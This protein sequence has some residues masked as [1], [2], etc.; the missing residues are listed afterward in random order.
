MELIQ[1]CEEVLVNIDAYN[2]PAEIRLLRQL[3]RDGL[4][5][6]KA[7]TA[8]Q[9]VLYPAS[10]WFSWAGQMLLLLG[11]TLVLAGII[12]FFAYNWAEMSRLLKFALIE[13]GIVGCVLAAYQR[14]LQQLSG[15]ILLLSASVLVGVLLAVYGQV[16]QTGADAFG[17]F[18][19]WAALIFAW[20]MIGEF[21][22]LWLLWLV[23]LNTGAILYWQQ[24]GEP[25]HSIPYELLCLAIAVL[26]GI[27]LALREIGVRQDRTWLNNGWLRGLLLIAC[28]VPLSIPTIDLILAF[29]RNDGMTFVATCAW[30]AT[31]A[32]GYFCY[33]FTVPDMSALALIVMNA[34]VILL[35][36]VGNFLFDTMNFD[37]AGGFLLFALIILAVVSGAALFLRRTATAMVKV[38]EESVG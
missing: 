14:G 2:K 1:H 33:R 38:T 7:L 17:L 27:A 24:V 31:V 22:A 19:G 37:D 12:F 36:L 20:V 30:A 4:L 21:A 26:N 5:N 34:C 3:N 28:L 16:Y 10:A 6:D 25:A 8:A 11:S 18:L 29:G 35:T 9:A 32:G 13:A 23:L 15:K